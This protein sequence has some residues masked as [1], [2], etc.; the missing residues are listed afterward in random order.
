MRKSR[1]FIAAITVLISLSTLFSSCASSQTALSAVPVPTAPRSNL[2]FA[3]N[4]GDFYFSIYG[5]PSFLLSRNPTA[6]YGYEFSTLLEWARQGG[7]KILRIHIGGGWSDDPCINPD[8]SVNERW[9]RKWD[10]F[11]DQAQA[12]RIYI[13]PVFGVWADWNN[14]LPADVFHFWQYNP[15]QSILRIG[16]PT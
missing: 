2:P 11:F 12:D 6:K 14:G 5:K 15:L 9:A 16:R 1:V 10:G 13:I 7:T 8:W 4:R 3:L